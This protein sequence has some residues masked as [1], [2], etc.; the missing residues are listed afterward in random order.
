[1]STTKRKSNFVG[2]VAIGGH[3]ATMSGGNR[4]VAIGLLAFGTF[5]GLLPLIIRK[6]TPAI[7]SQ[8]KALTG[9]QRQRGMF[10]QF[11]SSDVGPDP[12]W[13]PK[14]KTWKGWDKKNRDKAGAYQKKGGSD[15]DD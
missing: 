8:E 6:A 2:V 11:G 13:D 1:M 3:L 7:D 9:T 5:M 14:T 12:D 4:G 10:L 15:R